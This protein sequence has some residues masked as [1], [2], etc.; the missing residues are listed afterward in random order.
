MQIENTNL[1]NNYFLCLTQAMTTIKTL[2]LNGRIPGL[3]N[4]IQNLN[5]L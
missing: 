4:D 1:C 2:L 5:K 3:Q